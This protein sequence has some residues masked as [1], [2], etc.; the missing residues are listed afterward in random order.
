MPGFNRPTTTP[1]DPLATAARN[2]GLTLHRQGGHLYLSRVATRIGIHEH[3][4][5]WWIRL[6][7]TE[8]LGPF[9]DTDELMR[10]SVQALDAARARSREGLVRGR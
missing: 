2:V 7:A 10:A 5:H 9:T 4:G 6:T 8:E 1:T 3:Q